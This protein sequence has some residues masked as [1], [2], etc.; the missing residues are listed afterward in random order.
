[1]LSILIAWLFCGFIF[2]VSG[3]LL[4]DISNFFLKK[5]K[6]GVCDT[7]FLGIAFVGTLIS[8]VSLCT[9]IDV[10]LAWVLFAFSILY[11]LYLYKYKN[12]YFLIDIF[13]RIKQTSIS[14]RLLSV[15]MLFLILMCCML[16]P[17]LTDMSLYYMQ[18][19]LWNE[20]YPVI[21][22]LGNIHGRF[23]FNSNILVLSS[24]FSLKDVFSFRIYGV[25]G[26]SVFVLCIWIISKVVESKSLFQKL[27]LLVF[28][29]IFL[30]VYHAM[31]SSPSTDILPNI[32]VSFLLIKAIFS[33]NSILKSPLTYIILPVYAV[34]LKLSVIPICLL[35]IYVFVSFVKSKEYKI[36]FYL[37]LL[38]LLIIVPWCTRTVI[39][40][41]YLVYPF[42]S[43]DLFNFDWKIPYELADIEKRWVTSWAK[44]PGLGYVDLESMPLIEWGK[45]WL[46]RHIKYLPIQ[47]GAYLIAA[48]SPVVMLFLWRLKLININFKLFVWVAAFIG[49]VFWM[50][51]APDGRFGISFILATGLIPLFLI[52][53]ELQSKALKYGLYV[54]FVFLSTYI[55]YESFILNKEYKQDKPLISYFYS[56]QSLDAVKKMSETVFNNY[57]ID[58]ITIYYPNN[59]LCSDHEIPCAPYF[60]EH[61]EM[62]GK[63]IKEGFRYKK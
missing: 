28:C 53:K 8:F 18:S 34:T 57:Q 13:K 24:V 46:L 22:G 61:I 11:T 52:N 35:C 32:L 19:M 45:V 7:F 63:L 51:L 41:G 26:L 1:M 43:V 25:L 38:S 44:M 10:Y 33:D 39:I 17:V 12:D 30:Q 14:V 40:T 6:Y 27:G 5:G 56:P 59:M 21:P 48:I 60:N 3:K 54:L 47:L 9:N 15:L 23:G 37:V 2:L 62:R 31:I 20:T 55:F 49:F 42:P 50:I 4:I 58:D 29:L 36:S 16:P